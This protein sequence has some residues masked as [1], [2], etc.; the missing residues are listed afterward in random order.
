MSLQ[1]CGVLTVI[2][3]IRAA[4]L[5]TVF[6]RK[7]GGYSSSDAL[8]VSYGSNSPLSPTSLIKFPCLKASFYCGIIAQTKFPFY[9]LCYIQCILNVAGTAFEVFPL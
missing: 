1:G 9:I 2:V 8:S 6:R 7:C 5:T 3:Q 4:A